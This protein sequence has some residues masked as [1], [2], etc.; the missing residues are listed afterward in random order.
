M[1]CA[2]FLFGSA[3]VL[4]LRCCSC[5]L[6]FVVVLNSFSIS[7]EPGHDGRGRIGRDGGRTNC[8]EMGW[9]ELTQEG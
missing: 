7:G 1:C 4:L 8:D 6:F 9:D 3:S 2:V 5:L